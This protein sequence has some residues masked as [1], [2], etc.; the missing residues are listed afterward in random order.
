[1]SAAVAAGL[2]RPGNPKPRLGFGS[3]REAVLALRARGIAPTEIAARLGITPNC[4][5]SHIHMAGKA[6]AA[7]LP[8]DLVEALAP[9]A[10]RRGLTVPA[11]AVDLLSEIA[12]AG[13]VDAILDDGAGAAM[14]QEQDE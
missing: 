2:R 3:T 5:R 12:E 6:A 9:H 10:A 8:L 13:L 1:M 4:A 11:L 7:P 14:E